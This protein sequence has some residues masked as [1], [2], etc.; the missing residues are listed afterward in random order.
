[1]IKSK[2]VL[3]LLVYVFLPNDFKIYFALWASLYCT[4]IHS[5][6]L[7]QKTMDQSIYNLIINDACRSRSFVGQSYF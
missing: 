4:C 3:K 5:F 6:F 2:T 1:M 7:L